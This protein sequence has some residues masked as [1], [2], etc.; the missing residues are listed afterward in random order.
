MLTA[1]ERIT[2]PVIEHMVLNLLIVAVHK[3]NHVQE[4]KL[5]EV[6]PSEYRIDKEERL[7]LHTYCEEND[8][9]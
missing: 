3:K 4:Q 9:C 5:Q 8:A 1:A 7:A 2:A 6:M